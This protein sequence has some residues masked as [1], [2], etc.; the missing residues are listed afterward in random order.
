MCGDRNPGLLAGPGSRSKDFLFR[1]G[2][3]PGIGGD[4]DQASPDIRIR[5]TFGDLFDKM[6]ADLF[7][8]HL[9]DH[10][11]NQW[12]MIDPR[13]HNNMYACLFRSV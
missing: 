1:F 6:T 13:S 2:H 4:L 12:V 10:L 5:N 8:A 3:W 9:P 7:I 11:W